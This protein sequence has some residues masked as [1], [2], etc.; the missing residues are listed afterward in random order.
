[1]KAKNNPCY[2][3]TERRVTDGYNCHS[4][5]PR[6]AKYRRELDD[7]SELIRQKKAEEDLCY[8]YSL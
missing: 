3:C 7:E 2:G 4:D 5:C 6:Y 1:M 8:R